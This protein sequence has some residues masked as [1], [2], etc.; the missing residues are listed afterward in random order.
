MEPAKALP[1]AVTS[2]CWQEAGR[3]LKG[4]RHWAGATSPADA[5]LLTMARAGIDIPSAFELKMPT[6]EVLDMK[7]LGPALI[8][9]KVKAERQG[10]WRTR[11][12]CLARATDRRGED[13]STGGTSRS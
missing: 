1:R 10:G 7:W 9:D 13:Q 5:M 8:G 12:R 2:S 11:R 3:L 4:P 6:G